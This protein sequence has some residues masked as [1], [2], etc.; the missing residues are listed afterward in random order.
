[1]SKRSLRIFNIVSSRVFNNQGLNPGSKLRNISI[2]ILLMYKYVCEGIFWLHD[3]HP[4]LK[5]RSKA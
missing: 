3:Y 4:D 5:T 2:C 1:M